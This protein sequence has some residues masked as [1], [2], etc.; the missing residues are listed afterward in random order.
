MIPA[1][2]SWGGKGPD[3]RTGG[4]GARSARIA[5]W[6]RWWSRPAT[7]QREL[8][9]DDGAQTVAEGEVQDRVGAPALGQVVDE[10]QSPTT[11]GL[12]PVFGVR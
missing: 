6:S 4:L 8:G 9:P 5:P 1:E 7:A 3:G 10:Q 2:R 12:L 11:L